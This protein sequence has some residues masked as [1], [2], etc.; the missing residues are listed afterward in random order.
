MAAPE[1]LLCPLYPQANAHRGVL[2]LSGLWEFQPDPEDCGVSQRWYE[3]GL[4]A[5]RLAAVPGSWGEQFSE[6]R[7]YLGPC[8]YTRR[9]TLPATEPL[10]SPTRVL[11]RVGAATYHATVWLASTLLT[12]HEGGH[13]PFQVDV[14][15]VARGGGP[16]SPAP[17]SLLLALRVEGL[18]SP[19]RVPPGNL[20]QIPQQHPNIRYARTTGTAHAV[21]PESRDPR[22]PA[23]TFSLSAEYTAT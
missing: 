16:Q 21:S 12:V 6:L 11:L 5:P 14:T 4:P 15:A 7:D 18:M 1:P 2:D 3:K 8:W 9:V 22:D 20:A 23:W 17:S 13:L 19:T 10:S